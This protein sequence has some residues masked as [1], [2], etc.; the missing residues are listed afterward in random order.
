MPGDETQFGSRQDEATRP[1]IQGGEALRA[2]LAMIA[3][4]RQFGLEP[5]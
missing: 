4:R 3:L 1:G 2:C 5:A